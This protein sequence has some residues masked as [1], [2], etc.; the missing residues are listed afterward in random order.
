MKKLAYAL[1]LLAVAPLGALYAAGH[2]QDH[3]KHAM[4]KPAVDVSKVSGGNYTVDNHHAQ[5]QWQVSHLNF[6]DY[7]GLF[8]QIMGT[9]NLDKANPAASSVK[10]T[11]PVSDLATS[12]GDL[13]K[14]MLSPDFLD[15]AKFPTAT[16]ESTSVAVT[17][18][19]AAITGNLTLLGVTK[20]VTLKTTLSGAGSNMMNKKETIG[21]HAQTTIK[22]SDWGMTKY[23]PGIGYSVKLKI[24]IAFEKAA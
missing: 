23:V 12:R 9:L 24:S 18:Q 13:T 11:I 7:F 6:N 19:T 10:I 8:G 22:R 15:V 21:F 4:A 1:P 2:Q 20:P 5:V 3:A 17:G 14:H 16:F